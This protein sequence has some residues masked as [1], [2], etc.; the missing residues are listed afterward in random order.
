MVISP[1]FSLADRLADLPYFRS[2]APDRME[3][4]VSQALCRPFE[5]Q[6]ILF[7]QGDLDTGLWVIAEG[8]VKISKSS[9][10]GR[11]H[12]LFVMGSG[13]SFNEI[14]TLDDGPTAASAA[15]L[16][17]GIAWVLP[18][19][20][21]Q[22]EIRRDPQLALTVIGVLTART[23]TLVQQIEDLALCS[24]LARLARFLIKQTE[25]PNFD[26]ISRATMAA[27]LATTPETVSRALRTL[28]DIGAIRFDRH[29][30]K[31][32]KPELLRSVAM[33]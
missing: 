17:D 8:R 6:E 1:E 11:E 26:G 27:H 31:I 4:L 16:T 15:A 22:A 24:V 19:A 32:I 14:P 10:D 29:Q 3:A 18:A 30:I 25:Q 12:I 9:L 2:L 20:V 13:D 23:R 5:A 28:E 33:E 7:L 21:L